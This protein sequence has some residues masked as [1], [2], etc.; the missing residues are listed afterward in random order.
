MPKRARPAL[1]VPE[2]AANSN[3]KVVTDHPCTHPQC[4]DTDGVPK[5]YKSARTL[6]NHQ[7]AHHCGHAHSAD[8]LSA[9]AV[10]PSRVPA[11]RSAQYDSDSLADDTDDDGCVGDSINGGGDIDVGGNDADDDDDPMDTEVAPGRKDDGDIPDV[12]DPF[13]D[14]ETS[15]CDSTR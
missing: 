2:P 6:Q 3:R 1:A 14:T 5:Y 4:I 7:R 12:D 13:E 15:D 10:R 11:A 9:N 8:P